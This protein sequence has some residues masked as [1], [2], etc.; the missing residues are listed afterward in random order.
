MPRYYTIASSSKFSP[1][2]V[3]IAISLSDYKSPKGKRFFGITSEYLHRIYT[4]G[5]NTGSTPEINS[6]IFIKDSLFKYPEDPST[7]VVMVGPGTGV[8]P[9]I[10]FAEER[11]KLME[12]TPDVE[13]GN[14][15]LYFGCKEDNEDYIY[16]DEIVQYQ[17]DNRITKVYEAFSRHQEKKVYVQDLIKN[18]FD[19]IR[20][21][22]V[23]K[24]GQFFI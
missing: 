3:R 8:V 13:L 18:N 4:S 19:E 10:A 5:F 22:I 2:K 7:P 9:F 21:A 6:R 20:E 1:T 12:E 23:D 16:K 17:E 11:Q 15:M 14:G 24:N